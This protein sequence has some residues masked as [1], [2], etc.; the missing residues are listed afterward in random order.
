M[1]YPSLDSDDW[2]KI[3]YLNLSN[4]KLNHIPLV[5]HKITAIKVLYFS[6]NQLVKISPLLR[7]L[8]GLEKLYIHNNP[9]LDHL[10]DFLWNIYYLKELKIDGSLIKDHPKK[11]KYALDNENLED[12]IVNLT[13]ASKNNV[14][15][16]DQELK[17]YTESYI[18]YLK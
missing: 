12:S 4:K 6:N 14:K 13:L 1:S 18:V 7:E 11:A 2:S 5:V 15:M 10:P 17:I 8:R 3:T 9:N 16:D